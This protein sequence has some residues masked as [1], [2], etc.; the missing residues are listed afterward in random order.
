MCLK[1]QRTYIAIATVP[2]VAPWLGI[3]ARL[4]TA[5]QWQI[6]LIAIILWLVGGACI[7]Y[8]RL[9][10]EV[11]QKASFGTSIFVWT[12]TFAPLFGVTAAVTGIA[13]SHSH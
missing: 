5:N 12:A 4:L 3:V 9:S 6:V 8:L 7:W 11:A 10:P 13:I 2:E 1:P